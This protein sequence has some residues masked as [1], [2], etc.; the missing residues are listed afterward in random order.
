M[1]A[2]V[3]YCSAI[4]AA[5]LTS[6]VWLAA[7]ATP[8]SIALH[9]PEAEVQRIRA[10]L[11]AVEVELLAVD[12]SHLTPAQRAARA[13]HIRVLREYRRAGVFPHNHT[14]AAGR[15][16]VFVDEHGTHCAVGY[17]LARDGRRDLVERVRTGRNNSTVPELAND[18]DLVAWLATAGLTLEE[19]A[20][21]QPTYEC[22]NEG[23]CVRIEEGESSHAYRDATVVA[24]GL[25]GVISIWNLAVAGNVRA[26]DVPGLFGMGVGITEIALGVVGL[27][28]RAGGS[29]QT[30]SEIKPGHIALNVGVGAIAGALGL[31]NLVRSD[32]HAERPIGGG[33]AAAQK[34]IEWQL[35]PWAP[36]LSVNGGAGVRVDVRF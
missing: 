33:A 20:R 23:S 5:A 18:P 24:S 11:A 13:H 26:R 10:H 1:R 36:S 6:A 28:D 8:L 30:R 9:S 29:E 4:T 35:S 14:H 31:R 22:W 21:I 32:E 17:L 34:G 27:I 12:V 25:G 7:R 15:V 16:P 19:A 2:R 3:Y